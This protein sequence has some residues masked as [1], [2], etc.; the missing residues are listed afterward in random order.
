MTPRPAIVVGLLVLVATAGCERPKPPANGPGVITR[1]D[2]QSLPSGFDM[3]RYYPAQAAQLSINGRASLTC[4][5]TAGG[6][7]NNCAVTAEDPPGYEFGEAAL[8][9]AHLFKMKPQTRDG[10]PVAGATVNIPIRF[11]M[12]GSRPEDA[13]DP[14]KP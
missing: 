13:S 5:V 9:M 12:Q 2:W 10:V 8:R 11:V 7:V 1:P 14:G 3:S 4:T 6:R